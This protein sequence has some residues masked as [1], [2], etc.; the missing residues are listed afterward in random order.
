MLLLA[1]SAPAAAANPWAIPAEGCSGTPATGAGVEDATP[2]PFKTGD[3]IGQE[4]V[5]MLRTYLPAEIWEHRERF[6]FHGMQLEI[7]PCYRDY[8][9]PV[10]FHDATAQFRGKP[11][12]DEEGMLH[13]YVAGLPF[14][15]DDIAE[16][17]PQAGLKWAWNWVSRYGAG[18]R[19]GDVQLT[20][21]ERDSVEA[22]FRGEFFLV[23]LHFRADRP[24]DDYRFPIEHD[25]RWVSGGETKNLAGGHTCAWRQY[26]TGGR[27]P[28]VFFWN[29]EARKVARGVSPDSEG[30]FMGCLAGG[31]YSGLYTHGGSPQL[32]SWTL[33]GMRDLLT[34]IN[35]QTPAYP[36]DKERGFGPYG[37]SFANDRWDLRR[38][39]VIEG[40]LSEGQFNDGVT[41]YR[42]YLDLQTLQPL[43]YAAYHADG[44]SGGIGYFVG[45]WSEDRDDYPA[46]PDAPD[47]PV[48]VIDTVGIALVDWHQLEAVRIEAWSTVATPPKDKKIKRMISQ[49]GLRGR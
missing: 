9:P 49:S 34:P 32:H 2:L 8:S 23:P 33:V 42:W 39:L 48:R 47:R 5:E 28:D 7:G 25:S 4:Q 31:S 38:A 3:V 20:W 36:L 6:F 37:I 26:D 13:D 43:Y 27:R 1:L 10:F 19:Y 24:D 22:R 11:R 14:A 30:P 16:D 40:Q 45:R 17:D 15:P 12:L 44:T 29:P 18:G 35:A 46:W 21:V 41:R